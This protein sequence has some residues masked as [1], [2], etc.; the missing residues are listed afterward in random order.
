MTEEQYI[1]LKDRYLTNIKR[2]MTE[3]G[4]LFSHICVFAEKIEYPY[5]YFFALH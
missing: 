1:E 4:G 2:Y 5:G 3:E